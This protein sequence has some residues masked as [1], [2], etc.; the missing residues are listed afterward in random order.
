MK[1]NTHDND[2]IEVID[3]DTN[4][5]ADARKG[6]IDLRF[7]DKLS[8]D[9]TRSAEICTETCDIVKEAVYDAVEKAHLENI[10]FS[11]CDMSHF[12]EGLLQNDNRIRG[13]LMEGE[14]DNYIYML[15]I[16]TDYGDEEDDLWLN[17]IYD[18]DEEESDVV[19]IDDED[20]ELPPIE[21]PPATFAN[22]FRVSKADLT[23]CNLF[24]YDKDEWEDFNYNDFLG[25]TDHQINMFLDDDVAESPE[26]ELLMLYRDAF[27]DVS[28]EEF[29]K[30]IDLNREM[31]ALYEKVF[32]LADIDI[33]EDKTICLFPYDNIDGTSIIFK[34]GKYELNAVLNDDII[35]TSFTTTNM[36]KMAEAFLGIAEKKPFKDTVLI[37]P[38]SATAF[39]FV[40]KD[41]TADCFFTKDRTPLERTK[42]ENKILRKY[43]AAV[44][45][46]LNS[47]EK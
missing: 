30:I 13:I 36:N 20:E 28:D 47:E 33:L 43:N 9:L 8:K 32:H 7:F 10:D 11:L 23:N 42:K 18:D 44:N 25:M 26:S 46:L 29:D 6:F 14:D 24:N 12:T 31:L 37:F 40:G 2:N 27:G 17:D 5:N 15:V 19:L 45:K 16:N 1:K 39:I 21:M 41:G 35:E 3:I 38:L 4:V 22:A 34:N